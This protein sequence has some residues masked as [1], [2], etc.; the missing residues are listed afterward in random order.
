MIYAGPTYFNTVIETM[1]LQEIEMTGRQYT[2]ANDLDP[3]TYEK[4]DRI[5]MS[6]EWEAISKGLS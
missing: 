2:W 3:P 6:T 1:D 5:L 4:L